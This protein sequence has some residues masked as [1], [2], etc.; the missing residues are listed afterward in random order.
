[1][2]SAENES[3]PTTAGTHLL[4]SEC[5]ILKQ[6]LSIF[7]VQMPPSEGQ[8]NKLANLRSPPP[9]L[10]PNTIILGLSPASYNNNKSE[11][12][13]MQHNTSSEQPRRNVISRSN[14]SLVTKNEL[15]AVNSQN[16]ETRDVSLVETELNTV[17]GKNIEI[18]R[19]STVEIEQTARIGFN[20]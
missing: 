13:V 12:I 2:P 16:I 20:K 10:Q 15:T 5:T 14:L 3:P 7:K 17:E 11:D 9:L 6:K 8:V 1:M 4:P 18:D 19:L